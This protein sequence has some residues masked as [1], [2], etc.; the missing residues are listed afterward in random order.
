VNPTD[1][2]LYLF[3]IT[4]ETIIEVEKIAKFFADNAGAQRVF[5]ETLT[6]QCAVTLGARVRSE[7]IHSGIRVV[8][9]AP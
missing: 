5:Q 2:D 9:E 1:V 8:C 6:Q 3:T 7:G 4:S